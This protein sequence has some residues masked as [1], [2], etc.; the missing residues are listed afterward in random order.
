VSSLESG[1]LV[2]THAGAIKPVSWVGRRRLERNGAPWSP[3]VVPVRVARSALGE[4]TPQRDL[5]LSPAH[6]VYVDGLLVT[7]ASLINGR[8]IARCGFDADVIEYFHIELDRHDIILAEGLAAETFPPSADHSQ[9]DNGAEYETIFGPQ[10]EC[11]PC[12]PQIDLSGRRWQL[13]SRLRSAIAPLVDR[14]T[15]FDRLRDAIEDRAE[16]MG[17]AT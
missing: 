9:F 14:R 12:V 3:D 16:R 10:R 17:E 5:Y 7:V 15:P 13:A 6:A 1:D 8:T 11:P 2:I 4:N